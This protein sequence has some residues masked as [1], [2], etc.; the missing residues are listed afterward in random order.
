MSLHIGRRETAR[1]RLLV[2]NLDKSKGAQKPEDLGMG[3]WI[4]NDKYKNLLV[5]VSSLAVNPDGML[6]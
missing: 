1:E 3:Q 6:M 5:D 2:T 4:T